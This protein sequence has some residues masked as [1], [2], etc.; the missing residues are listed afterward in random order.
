MTVKPDEYFMR[1]ALKEAKK[2]VGRTSPNPAVGAVI[3]CDGNIISKGYHKKAGM[4][5]AEINAIN[6][7]KKSLSGTTIYVTL[8]PCN[9]TGKTPPCTQAI[10]ENGISR[11]VVGMKDPN[12]LVSGSGIDYLRQKGITVDSGILEKKCRDINRPFIKFITSGLPWVIM[13]A[14]VSLDGRLNYQKGQSGWITGEQSVREV[15]K[16]RNKVDAILVGRGTVEIDNPS[17]TTRL[18]GKKTEDPVRI[19]VDSELSLPLASRVLH[20]DSKASTWIFCRDGLSEEKK[21]KYAKS[22]VRI[23]QV[24]VMGDGLDLKKIM[25]ILGRE[26]ICSVLVEG[27]GQMHS[28]LLRE[29]I[30]DYAHIFHAPVLAGDRG[31]SLLE[32]YSVTDRSRSPRLSDVRYKRVGDDMMVSGELV[33]Y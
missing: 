27:G 8:E 17:L 29:R 24:P 23:F 13:K 22:G 14:G 10:I 2:G 16:L 25:T 5:H 20:L 19:V 31:V 33:Y 26:S 28:S 1:V 32:G 7:A 4:P 6:V 9:H 30:Y 12:P 3:V 11:V 18:T 15:H 21:A